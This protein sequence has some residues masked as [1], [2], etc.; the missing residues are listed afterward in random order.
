MSTT[1]LWTKLSSPAAMKI[2]IRD[3][4]VRKNR[5]ENFYHGLLLGLLGHREDWIVTSN[6]E[7]GDGYSDILVELAEE[8]IGIVIEVKYAEEKQLEAACTEALAQIARMDYDAR[9]RQDG[10]DTIIRYGIGCCRKKCK[11]VV[12]G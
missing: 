6:A 9:L 7:S 5:K 4:A 11:V 2:S 3:T 1:C 8:G 10:M 12:Q